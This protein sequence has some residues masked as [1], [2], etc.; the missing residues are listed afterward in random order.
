[1]GLI[2]EIE[3]T[4]FD[5]LKE[6]IIWGPA[7]VTAASVITAATPTPKDDSVVKAAYSIIE[8]MALVVG[9]AKEK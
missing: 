7:V 2:T 1:M 3:I 6:A 5:F 8:A 4:M 9:K